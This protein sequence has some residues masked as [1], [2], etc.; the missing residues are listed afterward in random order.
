MVAPCKIIKNKRNIPMSQNVFS[1][2]DMGQIFL[3]LAACYACFK[4][5]H[6]K[7]VQDTIEYLEDEGII[8]TE[9]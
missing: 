4:A 1:W 8:E 5:G 2:L 9:E 3:M 6:I 7:G